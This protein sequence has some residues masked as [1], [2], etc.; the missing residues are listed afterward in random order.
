MKDSLKEK[1]IK[2][3]DID[4]TKGVKFILEEITKKVLEL[5]SLEEEGQVLW[6]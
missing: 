1:S 5:D 3:S 4:Q 2:S 6:Q